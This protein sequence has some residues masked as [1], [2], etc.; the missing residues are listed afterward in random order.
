MANDEGQILTF[1]L[2][3]SKLLNISL[4]LLEYYL[5]SI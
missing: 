5:T 1:A 4:E 2:I 3:S